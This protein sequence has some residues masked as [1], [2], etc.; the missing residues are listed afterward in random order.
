MSLLL[1]QVAA[2]QEE[3]GD[4]NV[5]LSLHGLNPALRNY[6]RALRLFGISRYEANWFVAGVHEG[7]GGQVELRKKP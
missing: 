2:L 5:R 6:Y 7:W 4:K 3:D 1:E